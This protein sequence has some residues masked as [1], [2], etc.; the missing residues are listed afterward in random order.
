MRP[1]AAALLGLASVWDVAC[2]AS[3]VAA[4]TDQ[5]A[6][7]II[8]ARHVAEPAWSVP[9]SF[10]AVSAQEIE[11]AQIRDLNDLADAVPGLAY[12]YARGQGGIPVIRGMSSPINNLNQN[13]VATV[14]DGIYIANTF[15][16]DMSLLDLDAIDVVRG[17]QNALIGRNAF[18][19]AILYQPATPLPQFGSGGELSVGTDAYDR[20]TAFI[21][22]PL[23]P[24]LAGRLAGMHEG[25]DGTITNSADP[26]NNLGGWQKSGVSAA[27]AWHRD[28][29]AHARLSGYWYAS[30]RDATP[31]FAVGDVPPVFNC[32]W[33]GSGFVNFC[34]QFPAPGAVDI[35]PD[36]RGFHSQTMLAR[37]ELG[38]TWPGVTLASLTGFI[39]TRLDNP[40]DEWDLSSAGELL[41]VE[42]PNGQTRLQL[43]NVYFSGLPEDDHEWS[44]ELRLAGTLARLQWMFGLYWAD[45]RSQQHAG[46]SADA[47]GLAPGELFAPPYTRVGTVTPL[48]IIPEYAIAGGNRYSAAFGS[49]AYALSPSLQV[50]A[51]LRWSKERVFGQNLSV[52]GGPPDAPIQGSWAFVTPRVTVSYQWPREIMAYASAA[53]GARSG[54]FNDSSVASEAQ[55]GSED[56]WTYEIGLKA[57]GGNRRV[58]GSIALYWVNWSDMQV[59]G[60]S[61]DP[62][63]QFSVTRNVGGATI[64]GVEL[65]LDATPTNWLDA[66][67]V[68]SYAH[69]RFNADAIDLGIANTCTPD[70][71]HLV[72]APPLQELV[73][74]VGGNQLPGAPQ[75]AVSVNLT[76]HAALQGDLR[77]Y[78]RAGLDAADREYARTDNLNWIAARTLP[79]ARLGLMGARWELAIWGRNLTSTLRSDHVATNYSDS[80][81]FH[82]LVDRANG[83][84]WGASFAYRFR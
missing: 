83:A 17:P 14:F 31:R 38:R 11:R 30:Q 81:D 3:A 68:Y 48:T 70:V 64:K 6:E 74:N 10:A 15:A 5:L 29:V 9:L 65:G 39:Q 37:L 21:N 82:F 13:N 32:G 42:L 16:V 43:A 45:N 35:S 18:A 24:T 46:Y 51:E 44:E 28:E 12:T 19:G 57:G 80:G 25:F 77:W 62:E 4:E 71:C 34:G 22:I 66:H 1:V 61:Q 59:E 69:A 20:E 7:V 79:S 47:R 56:N 49:L 33:D 58:Q 54:G 75:Q 50:S 53:K 67:L 63:S 84:S 41:Q 40:P 2:A 26:R 55:Y 8:T 27:L 76:F 23:S 78:L 52:T 73:P 72:P 60:P 36:A